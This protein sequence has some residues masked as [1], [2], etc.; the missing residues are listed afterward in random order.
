MHY[1]IKKSGERIRQ[2][3]TKAGYTQETLAE[4]LSIDRSLLSHMEAGRRGCSIDMLIRISEFFNVSLDW[5]IL[6]RE[7][8]TLL[9]SRSNELL[10]TDISE[11]VDH[12]NA[13][14][15]RL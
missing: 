10:K 5:I 12:L 4:E 11:L 14:K 8:R 13:L 15:E 6:G 2:L 1:D 9:R 3:R 7:D